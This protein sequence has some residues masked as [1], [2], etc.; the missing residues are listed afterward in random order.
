MATTPTQVTSTSL[1]NSGI[2]RMTFTK[3]DGTLTRDAVMFLT[4]IYNRIGGASGNGVTGLEIGMFEDA[5]SSETN[6]MLFTAEQAIAQTPSASETSALLSN[7]EQAFGQAPVAVL[8]A[9]VEALEAQIA[10]QRD[11]IAALTQEIQS[12]NQGILL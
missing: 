12:I 11:R 8:M 6:S 7:I 4:G 2:A 1:I 10:E 9:Q 3:D 5:G